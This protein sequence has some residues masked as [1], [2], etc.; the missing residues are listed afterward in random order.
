MCGIVGALAFGK[1]NKRDEAVRQ[2]IMRFFTTELL[3]NTETRGKDA[4]GAAILFSDGNFVG[5]KRGDKASEFLSKFGEG[6]DTYGGFLKVWHE[7]DKP[8]K[9]Y[10]GHCRAS[11][12]GEKED[13]VNNHPIK[14]GN[15]VGIH[16]GAIKNDDE[17]IKNLGCKREG[18]VDS[19]AIFRLFEYFTDNGKE[20][21]TTEMLQKIV[22]RLEGQ[23]AIVL[24]N[25]DN[26]YQVPVFR[27]GRPTEF[28]LVKEYGI[29]FIISE[30]NFWNDAHFKYERSI[31]YH[32]L[33]L[34]SLIDAGIEKE[35][36]QDDS[37]MIFDLT[38]KVNQDTR[39]KD[40]GEW[41]KMERT[42]KIWTSTTGYSGYPYTNHGG[43][44]HNG[45]NTSTEVS[46]KEDKK[47]RVFDKLG[48]RYVAKVGDTVLRENE[49]IIIPTETTEK[50]GSDKDD[51]L[52]KQKDL[53]GCKVGSTDSKAD[54]ERSKEPLEIKDYTDYDTNKKK[55]GDKSQGSEDLKWPNDKLVEVDMT[56][57]PCELVEAAEKAYKDIPFRNR[58]YSAMDELLNAVSI[59]DKG[60]AE[61]LGL[62]IVANRV[63]GDSWKKGFIG[64]CKHIFAKMVSERGEKE[65]NR[66]KYIVGLKSLVMLLTVYFNAA[67]IKYKGVKQSLTL[68]KIAKEYLS[69]PKNKSKI[70]IDNLRS[71]FNV[72]E[73]KIVETAFDLVANA[74]IE[75]EPAK[76]NR[77]SSTALL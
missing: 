53:P 75:G 54:G 29:L 62:I 13:N 42:N 41:S 36:L 27:D 17:I 71:I 35:S 21:F 37:C 45:S 77:S 23:F 44:S 72:G 61:E 67:S 58:G 28:V 65:K 66:E 43:S 52:D 47:T 3:V 20:P 76:E 38:K 70:D 12:G 59:K 63:Y 46:K 16:N 31:Y 25:A 30:S 19:E 9:V 50:K 60:A 74:E 8:V 24:F 11:T 10:L 32:G 73:K 33:R 56:Q 69:H 64:G 68:T 49:S 39:I 26:P 5:T 22:N 40:L 48:K 6:K 34:P 15:I 4:T 51:K 1:L 57:E 2:N 18:K 55:K 7:H 14:I